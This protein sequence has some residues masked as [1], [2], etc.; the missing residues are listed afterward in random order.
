MKGYKTV[1]IASLGLIFSVLQ[2][3]GFI[4][5]EADQAAIQTGLASITALVLRFM[6]DSK[7]GE[8]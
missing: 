5:P 4:V 2:S 8:K 3:Q 6:T 1:I 7:V